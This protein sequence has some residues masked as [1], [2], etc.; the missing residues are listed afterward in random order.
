MRFTATS[1]ADAYRSFVLPRFEVGEVVVSGGGVH[2]ATLMG[3]LK[4]ELEPEG[5]PVR[6]FDELDLGF[7]ADAKEAVA[8]AILANETV[9]G[10][11]SNL[12]AATGARERV[13]LGK[14]TL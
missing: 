7:T 14:I 2:N 5:I 10:R 6:S 8:F 12:P 1:I 9:Q 11:P 4:A 3:A 13:I